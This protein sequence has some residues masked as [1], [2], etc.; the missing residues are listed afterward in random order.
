MRFFTPYDDLAPNSES[1]T[2]K[3]LDLKQTRTSQSFP[4]VFIVLRVKDI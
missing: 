4:L 2:L 3:V 1:L